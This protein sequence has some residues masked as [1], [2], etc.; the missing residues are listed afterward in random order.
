MG[1]GMNNA[2]GSLLSG[3][4]KFAMAGAALCLLSAVYFVFTA[5]WTAMF[6]AIGLFL[7]LQVAIAMLKRLL[8]PVAVTTY[9]H[10]DIFT[11]DE[12]AE[13]EFRRLQPRHVRETGFADGAAAISRRVSQAESEGQAQ[14]DS[15]LLEAAATGD[16]DGVGRVVKY[17]AD[18]NA[19]DDFDDTALHQ[20]SANGHI[21]VVK[22]L[23]DNRVKVM[24]RNHEGDTPLK[25][26]IESG[27]RDVVEL[28]IERG[29]GINGSNAGDVLFEKGAEINEK[30]K[31]EIGVGETLLHWAAQ[32][33]H[34]QVVGLL[35]R[36]GA[37]VN[38]K[39]AC[40]RTP[41]HEAARR[42]YKEVVEILVARGADVN[43]KDDEDEEHTPLHEA[44][45][46]GHTDVVA[47][48]L[49]NGAKVSVIDAWGDTPLSTAIEIGH[50]GVAELLRQHGAVEEPDE[51]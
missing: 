47:I 24:A 13:L 41:L 49:A 31:D 25:L 22:V 6:V 38:A 42:G 40:D 3:L 37:G 27:Q 12:K 21:E 4:I 1:D 10:D 14:L 26:A 18:L 30:D 51:D 7:G 48:L 45:S 2:V 34:S 5:E 15:E 43:A 16:A 23:L 28:F 46:E 9:K 19:K 44:A 33:G 35:L 39:D 36:R 11:D 29:I 50:D 17:G 8:R 20:A 32:S